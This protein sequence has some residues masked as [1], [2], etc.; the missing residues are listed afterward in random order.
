MTDQPK[1]NPV[2]KQVLD[3]GPLLS[4]FFAN[5]FFGIF[6]A[7]GVVMIASV[8][9]LGIA[10]AQTRRLP[11]IPLVTAVLVLAFGSL[12]LLLHDEQFIKIKVTV[13]Y[14]LFGVALLVGLAFGKALIGIMLDSVSPLTELGQRKLTLRVALFC[15]VLAGVNEIVWRNVS[16]NAWVVFKVY[17][18]P[19]LLTAFLFVQILLLARRYAV[20]EPAE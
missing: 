8:I 16:T 11:I 6:V 9:A 19:V 18:A 12:T 13:V 7:T 14:V 20:P 3:F 4:F 10:Y 1:L 15:F 17:L 2:L 5:L